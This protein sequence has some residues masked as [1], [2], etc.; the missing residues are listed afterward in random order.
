MTK[1]IGMLLLAGAAVMA[2]KE[3]EAVLR[4]NEASRAF[5]EIMGAKDKGI[6]QNILEKAKCVVIVPGV[7]RAG[8]IIGGEYGK[9]EMSCR[10]STAG[11]TGPSTI[12][13]EG[14]SIGAQ[15]GGGETDL[16]L[17]VMNDEGARKLMKS[18]FKIGGDA[19]VMAGP[20]GRAAEADTDAFMRA[21]MLAYSRA[22]GAFAGITLKG[23]TLRSDDDDNA[24]IYGS[25]VSHED[26]LTGK[27]PTPANSRSFV[28]TLNRYF[29]AN[30]ATNKP[31]S[32]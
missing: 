26:I 25:K 6:P 1:R 29:R 15:I 13:V 3:H 4:V 7:K 27:V 8:F 9:G 22:R 5:T 28:A 17:V 21:E 14:G 2:A 30:P 12:R 11:F 23:T 18:E 31:M 32:K 19:A 20:V 24:K 16:I 10:T